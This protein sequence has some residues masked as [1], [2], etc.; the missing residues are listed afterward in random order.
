MLEQLVVVFGALVQ[1]AS[2]ILSALLSGNCQPLFDALAQLK[3]FVTE[4]AGQAWEHLT[5]FLRPVGDFFSDLWSSYGAPAV[6]LLQN[7]AGDLWNSIRQLGADIWEWTQPVRDSFGAAWN[8]I[9]RQ[10]F[11]PEDEAEGDSSGGIIGWITRKAGEAWDWVREQTRPIWEPVSQALER[12]RELIPP[13]FLQEMGENMQG[14]AQ[15][16][17]EAGGQM[18]G[19]ATVAENRE[20]LAAV[21]Q[22][23]SRVRAILV[24]A[25][26]WIMEKIT[27]LAEGVG[28]FMARLR[29]SSL[30]GRSGWCPFLA[31]GGVGAAL[32]LGA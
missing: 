15:N 6:E 4:V 12:V 30:I 18:Q 26:G 1:Q 21:Q 24:G 13:A 22:V 27:A 25:G 7:F 29:A 9:K 3:S 10:L 31:G 11:G 28:S 23:L 2:V 8:W 5:E 20:A 19:G 17:N 14:L 32:R 16:L